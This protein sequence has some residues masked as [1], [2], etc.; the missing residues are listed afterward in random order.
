MQNTPYVKQFDEKGLLINP[1]QGSYKST[2]PNRQQRKAALKKER[3]MNFSKKGGS[4]LVVIGRM[5]FRKFVQEIRVPDPK[6]SGKFLIKRIY[7]TLQV[8]PK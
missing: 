8:L 2:G 3:F 5:K 6:R 7:Q 1:I 4:N